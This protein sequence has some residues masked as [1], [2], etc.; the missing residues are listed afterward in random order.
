MVGPRTEIASFRVVRSGWRSARTFERC[1]ETRPNA[2]TDPSPR[3]ETVALMDAAS[4]LAAVEAGFRSCGRRRC[5]RS[6]AD[7]YSGAGR[8]LSRQRRARGAGS[9]LCRRQSQREL[10]RQS[11]SAKACRRSRASCCFGDAANGSL[12]AV[13]DSIEITF[14]ENCRCQRAGS[15]IP[16]A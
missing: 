14:E 16:G 1:V 5:L 11:A 12:L 8:W 4:Y 6:N 7:A 13:I 10:P 3:S 15:A 2:G 9:R